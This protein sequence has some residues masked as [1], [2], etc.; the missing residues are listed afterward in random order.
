MLVIRMMPPTAVP[1]DAGREYADDVGRYRRGDDAAEQQR[2]DYLP[3]YLREA[4]REQEPDAGGDG[5][6][7]LAGVDRADDLA[8][9][10]T[11]RRE[12]GGRGDRAPTPAAGR[13]EEAGHQTQRSQETPRDRP[14][15][16]GPLRAPE[17]EA[18]QHV[19]AEREQEDGDDRRH[20]LLGHRRDPGHRD[21]PEETPRRRRAPPSRR[22]WTSPRCRSAS[23]TPR[24]PRTSQPRRCARSPTPAPARCP[25]PTTASS[26]SPRRPSQATRPPAG[27]PDPLSPAE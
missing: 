11:A 17:R 16:H 27:R 25:P 1:E 5:D 7:E 9:L 24:T 22:S 20:Q 14:L 6:E 3:R 13:V 4:E 2:P 12:Q 21:R 18:G 8:R 15:L 26:R 10:H 23:A 19:H